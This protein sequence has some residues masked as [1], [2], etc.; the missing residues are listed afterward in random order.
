MP[1][2]RSSII[3]GHVH[4]Y[5]PTRY[6]KDDP[7]GRGGRD[8]PWYVWKKAIMRTVLSQYRPAQVEGPIR[9]DVDFFLPRPDRLLTPSAPKGR[10]YHTQ[11]PDVDNMVKVVQDAMLPPTKDGEGGGVGVYRDDGQVCQGEPQKWFPAIGDATGARIVV[12][13]LE[14]VAPTMFDDQDI[15]PTELREREA[16]PAR[17]PARSEA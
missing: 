7:Q 12:T 14:D 3:A 4:V 13:L 10:L 9:L 15:L 2:P 1:R 6:P 8:L 17:P 11:R 16:A 5:T